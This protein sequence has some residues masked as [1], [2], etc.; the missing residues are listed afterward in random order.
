M[1]LGLRLALFKFPTVILAINWRIPSSAHLEFA[2]IDCSNTNCA[3]TLLYLSDIRDFSD[4][5]PLASYTSGLRPYL[6]S[7]CEDK[8]EI[9][10]NLNDQIDIIR[11][12]YMIIV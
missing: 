11:N 1:F 2:K 8:I 10:F 9:A 3:I 6:D 12:G 5:P 4:L 7:N